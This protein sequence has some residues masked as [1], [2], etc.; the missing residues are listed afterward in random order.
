MRILLVDDHDIIRRGVRTLLETRSDLEVVGEASTGLEAVTIARQLKPDIAIVDYSIPELNGRDLTGALK[1]DLPTIEVLIYT[2][3]DREQMVLDV[4]QAGARG[5][6][7]KSETER[8]LF[9][10]VDALSI[11][12]PYFSGAISEALLD[13]YLRCRSPQP[14]SSLLTDRERQV[15]Q[16]IAEG[17]MNKEIACMLSISLKTVETHRASAIRKLNLGTTADLVRY[18]I[19]HNIAAP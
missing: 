11:H 8:H 9:A 16:L 6:V 17:K 1:K 12:Q 15:V 10:A 4:L 14:T 7:L 3:H 2:M 18:A 19:R 13:Q 5:F